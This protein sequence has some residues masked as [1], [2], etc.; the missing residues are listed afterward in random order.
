MAHNVRKE[1]KGEARASFSV[2]ASQCAVELLKKQ[3]KAGKKKINYVLIATEMEAKDKSWKYDNQQVRDHLRR[4][5]P[6]VTGL[7]PQKKKKAT[8]KG[9]IL[10]F[11]PIKE[12]YF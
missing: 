5:D 3:Q 10:L 9:I 2:A 6:R 7:K 11:L 4:L 8:S 12:I 1:H